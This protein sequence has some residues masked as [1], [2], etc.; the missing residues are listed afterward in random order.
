MIYS[1]PTTSLS[2]PFRPRTRFQR[3]SP[4]RRNGGAPQR[5]EHY[6]VSVRCG[7]CKCC[8]NT[9]VLGERKRL[10]GV[11]GPWSSPP[12][13]PLSRPVD[14]QLLH[15]S[16]TV[17]H[18]LGRSV[19]R[20]KDISREAEKAGQEDIPHL[21][22]QVSIRG[23]QHFVTNRLIEAHIRENMRSA[24]LV[25]WP[26]SLPE[27]FEDSLS[28][29]VRRTHASVVAV[30]DADPSRLSSMLRLLLDPGKTLNEP[31]CGHPGHALGRIRGVQHLEV[32][33]PLRPV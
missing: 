18:D 24:L 19:V 29:L 7:W 28:V 32:P 20:I 33:V 30:S 13:V 14:S 9:S 27:R 21:S 3:H 12:L 22:R 4:Y 1:V 8:G 10:T 17:D 23:F 31:G 16:P 26:S 5:S 25:S 2:S 11:S 15:A 6:G